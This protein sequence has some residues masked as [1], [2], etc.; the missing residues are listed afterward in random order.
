M[1]NNQISGPLPAALGNLTSLQRIVLHQNRLVGEVPSPLWK[2]GCIVNL[3]GNPGLAHG[4]DVPRIERQAL[5]DLYHATGG[6]R[7]TCKTGII[8]IWENKYLCIDIISYFY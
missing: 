5:E 7:W 4:A 2:L 8:Y 6:P 1:G 3:A